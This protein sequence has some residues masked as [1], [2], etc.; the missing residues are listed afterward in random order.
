[1]VLSL[2]HFLDP[3]SANRGDEGDAGR[4]FMAGETFATGDTDG[5]AQ[6][7]LI[8]S[9]TDNIDGHGLAGERMGFAVHTTISD[10]WDA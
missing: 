9:E 10:T 1:M 7:F 2:P 3:L 5:G 4:D 6:S 8:R